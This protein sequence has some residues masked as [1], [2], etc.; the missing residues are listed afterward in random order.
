MLKYIKGGH[1]PNI[2]AR[3]LGEDDLK[4][5]MRSGAVKDYG[6]KITTITK[7]LIETGVYEL[8]QPTKDEKDAAD[9]EVQ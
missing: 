8:A 3:D 5:L 1:I 9:D 2:P 4:S 6:R 7:S